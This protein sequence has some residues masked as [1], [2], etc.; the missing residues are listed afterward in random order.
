MKAFV[1]DFTIVMH[2][3]VT[4]LM[5]KVFNKTLCKGVD[6]VAAP[7][8]THGFNIMVSLFFSSLITA[9]GL[10]F[11]TMVSCHT[12]LCVGILIAILCSTSSF[13]PLHWTPLLWSFSIPSDM[14][15][16]MGPWVWNKPGVLSG[17]TGSYHGKVILPDGL[18]VHCGTCEAIFTC[19]IW[20]YEMPSQ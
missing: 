7:C 13:Y 20:T 10:T 12:H 6:Y 2:I 8:F 14:L 1:K 11:P 15:N 19:C 16:P 3:H 9:L 4:L 18:P 17:G 5:Y